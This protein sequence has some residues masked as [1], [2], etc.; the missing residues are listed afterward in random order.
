VK[1][2]ITNLM[3]QVIS[4]RTGSLTAAAAVPGLPTSQEIMLPGIPASARAA[5]HFARQALSGCP[6]ADDLV[7]A[8][9][10]LVANAIA[11]SA[12]GQGGSIVVRVRTAHRWAGVQ[13]T[14]DG[15]A[16]GPLTEGNGYGLGIVTAVTDRA[17]AALGLGGRRTAWAEVS[18]PR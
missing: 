16:A 7:L 17:G 12:S 9:S 14:D 8:V 6:R 13:V 2:G 11:H 15:P 10:E 3:H 1:A 4:A 18:W 5:R